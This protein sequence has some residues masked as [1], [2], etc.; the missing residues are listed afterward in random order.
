LNLTAVAITGAQDYPKLVAKTL[1]KILKKFKSRFGQL[2]QFKNIDNTTEFDSDLTRMMRESTASR[3]KTWFI[4]GL[5]LGSGLLLGIY[6][7]LW[8]EFLFSIKTYIIQILSTPADDYTAFIFIFGAV[9]LSLE[10]K[11]IICFI[12]SAILGGY[13]AGS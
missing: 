5:I 2:E 12:P 10:V 7:L 1:Q 6:A 8:N 9:L 13:I 3:T 11:L 4:L